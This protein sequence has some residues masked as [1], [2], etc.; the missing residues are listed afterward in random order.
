MSN[1]KRIASI[2][3]V[4]IAG[5][6]ASPSARAAEPYACGEW[7]RAVAGAIK[8]GNEAFPKRYRIQLAR[9]GSDTQAKRIARYDTQEVFWKYLTNSTKAILKRTMDPELFQ[10]MFL[11]VEARS[12][13]ESLNYYRETMG[14][15]GAY[16]SGDWPNL[17]LN[18]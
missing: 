3:L 13:Q 16:T 5:V 9:Y 7:E 6:S 15:C 18:P 1:A 12:N 8:V 11:F 4:V 14:R 2:I 10:P 17:R